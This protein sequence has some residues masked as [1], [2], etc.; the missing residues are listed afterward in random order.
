M[1]KKQEAVQTS[2]T[3]AARA[4]IRKLEDLEAAESAMRDCL[5][6]LNTAKRALLEHVKDV[7]FASFPVAIRTKVDA[8]CVVIIAY[9]GDELQVS[10][11]DLIGA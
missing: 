2:V 5:A 1:N 7:D 10:V 9:D 6:E 11:P 4:Y 3:E 8:T